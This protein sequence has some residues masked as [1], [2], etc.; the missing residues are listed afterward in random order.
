[1]QPQQAEPIR[2]FPVVFVTDGNMVFD[3]FKGVASL[4]QAQQAPVRPFI[5]VGIGYP[6]ESPRAGAYLRGRD[7]IFPGYPQLTRQPPKGD[8]AVA[9]PE[10][11]AKD[12]YGAADFLDF[13]EHELIPQIQDQYPADPCARTYFGHS[14]GGGFGLFTLFTRPHVFKNYVISSPGLIYH[15]R[16]AGVEYDDY[17]FLLRNARQFIASKQTLNETCLYLSV[18]TEEEF[19]PGLA[20]WRL[21]SS[22]YR[23]AA[24]LRA[25]RIEGLEL[26]TEVLPGETHTTAWPVAFIHGICR[27]LGT[28]SQQSKIR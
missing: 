8:P 24:L 23:L 27:L 28:D 10:S 9:L 6:G 4:L 16:S 5:L 22:F 17:D 3:L 14:A 19:E 13:M 18:G 20:P 15:G 1:M 11:G 25:E 26:I 12:S 7:L 2:R 21:T